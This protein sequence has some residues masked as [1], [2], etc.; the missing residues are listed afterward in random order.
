MELHSRRIGVKFMYI[1]FK[2][3]ISRWKDLLAESVS[4]HCAARSLQ[5][6][7]FYQVEPIHVLKQ[8]LAFFGMNQKPVIMNFKSFRFEPYSKRSI[9]GYV[10]YWLQK[11][12]Q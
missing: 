3:L 2:T 9:A 8:I 4:E 5:K 7:V 6:Q 12:K 1:K 10:F 11:L